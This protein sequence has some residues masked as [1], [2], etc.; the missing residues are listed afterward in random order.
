VKDVGFLYKDKLLPVV[1]LALC[2]NGFICFNFRNYIKMC[3][4]CLEVG[5]V[6][7]TLIVAKF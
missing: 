1:L 5:E 7:G 4:V 2:A 3:R 6:F